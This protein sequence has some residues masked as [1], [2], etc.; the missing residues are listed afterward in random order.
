MQIEHKTIEL[1]LD[2]VDPE[3]TFEGYA[4]R[5]NNVDLGD[6]VIAPGAFKKTLRKSKGRVPIL[7]SHDPRNQIGWNAEASEDERGLLVK[8]RLNLEVQS[9]REKHALMKQA[10]EMGT[11]MGLSIGFRTIKW[12]FDRDTDVRTLKELELIEYSVVAFPMNIEARTTVVKMHP[13]DGETK[14][15]L[16]ALSIA[17]KRALER[18][19]LHDLKRVFEEG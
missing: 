2:Q 13:V 12:D 6:D 1:K 16:A 7:D 11:S 14:A 15:A 5:F 18:E 4:A 3:G 9:A 17:A 8:G 10:F 19:A